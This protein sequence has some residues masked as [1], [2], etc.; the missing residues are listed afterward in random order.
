M[1]EDESESPIL[2]PGTELR[3][4]RNL[5]SP[6][7]GGETTSPVGGFG[8]SRELWTVQVGIFLNTLGY[9]A[10]LPFEII[11]FHNGRGFSLSIAGLLVAA[12]TGVALVTGPL[13]GPLI[14]RLGARITAVGA[15]VLLAAGYAALAFAHDPGFAFAGAGLA[16]MGN[17]AL[18]PSQSALI[19]TLSP[20]DRRHRATAVS[21]VATNAGFGLGG[22][23]GGA[24]AATGLAG[25]AGL[26]LLNAATYL[27]YVCILA[28][29]VRES[30][31]PAPIAGGYRVVLRD[32]AFVHLALANVALIAVGWGVFSWL[33]PAFAKN[34][35][36]VGERLIGLL[37]LANAL[38]VVVAQVPIARLAEGHRRVVLMATAGVLFAIACALVLVAEVRPAVAFMILVGA[39]ILVGAGECF[40]TTALSPLV[41][42]LAPAAVRGRYMAAIGFSWWIGL[43]IAPAI[44]GRLLSS[45]P[46]ALF[47]GSAA[48]AIAASVALLALE[49]RLPVAVRRTPRPV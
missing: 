43:T 37:L 21:R 42:D 23:V 45:V 31:R 44:G 15:G 4:L 48:L 5:D 18:N 7:T 34:Y 49:R 22:A 39:A 40:H 47:T 19:A 30:P 2:P 6:L 20:A 35:L 32:G 29:V 28:A 3:C 11:Y 38:T 25:F 41:A 12:I 26:F 46:T 13:A 16:G 17:G 33:I 10:V 8:L 24:I 27:I 1:R 36:G 9:G 14:D